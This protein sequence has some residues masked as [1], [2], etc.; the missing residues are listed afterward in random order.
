MG[1]NKIKYTKQILYILFL[2]LF[3][4]F[5]GKQVEEKRLDLT[6]FIFI[7][8]GF[9][10]TIFCIGI[11]S[12]QCIFQLCCWDR[13][14]CTFVGARVSLVVWQTLGVTI[15]TGFSVCMWMTVI[16]C[17]RFLEP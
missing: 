16:S 4:L 14:F 6:K 9:L 11:H 5:E 1:Q 2:E 12:W 15:G 17:K 7:E 13:K 8:V 10:L 3:K